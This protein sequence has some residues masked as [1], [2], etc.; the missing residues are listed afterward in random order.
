MSS[1]ILMK[2]SQLIVFALAAILVTGAL[3]ATMPGI[4][5]AD[6]A[7]KQKNKQKSIQV[8][9]AESTI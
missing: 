5:S 3:V 1:N 9:A 7:D 2:Y 4:G 8:N 6:A